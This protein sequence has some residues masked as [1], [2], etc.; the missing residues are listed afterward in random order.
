[1][2]RVH[3]SFIHLGG[4]A[5]VACPTGLVATSNGGCVAPG[6]IQAQRLAASTP[7][8][9]VTY[10]SA[11]GCN[12]VNL[13]ENECMLDDGTITG[14]NIIQE[15]DSL[16][17]QLR[18]QYGP[19]PGQTADPTLPFCGTSQPSVS[20]VPNPNLATPTGPS[21]PFTPTTLAP[22]AVPVGSAPT[23]KQEQALVGN[24][25]TIAAAATPSGSGG[26]ASSLNP[27]ALA[28]AANGTVT[29]AGTGSSV[30]TADTSSSGLSFLTDA[31][32]FGIP[33]WITGL[34]AIGA[35]YLLVKK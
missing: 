10:A 2:S 27:S 12:V 28:P 22:T 5:Q 19:F 13:D 11:P 25:Q 24:T 29:T 35:I 6:S 16:T 26:P 3:S 20:Y 17:G 32:L 9:A 21:T 30:T 31:S 23:A 8:T 15:C 34:V 1:M 7:P 18:C 33:N 4:L 14:C